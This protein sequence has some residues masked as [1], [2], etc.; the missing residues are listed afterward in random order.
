MSLAAALLLGLAAP[1]AASA[2]R[3]LDDFRAPRAWRQT[4]SDGVTAAAARFDGGLRLDYDFSR[5]AGYAVLHRDLALDLPENFELRFRLRGGG[6]A[7]TLELKLIDASGENVWWHRVPDLAA[8]AGWTRMRVRRRQIDFAWGPARDHALGQIAAI[9]F[10]V[11]AGRGGGRGWIAIDDLEIVPLPVPPAVPPPVTAN[12]NGRLA[13]DG[14]QATAWRGG[15]DAMLDLDLGYAREFGGLRLDW[16]PNAAPADY[17]ISLSSDGLHWTLA[18]AMR[19]SDGGTDWIRLPEAEARFVRIAPVR[20][21]VRRVALAEA[22]IE[23]LAFGASDNDFVAVVAAAAPRGAYPRG[24]MASQNYWTLVAPPM[25]GRN[26]LIDEA[27]AIEFGRGGVSVEPF[28]LDGGRAIGW[29]DGATAQSLARGDLPIPSVERTG[30][31]WRLRITALAAPGRLIGRYTLTNVGG[32]QRR[33]VLLLAV[34]PFQV[35]PPQQF[36]GG[37]GGVSPI[38]SLAWDGRALIVNAAA[39]FVPGS[40]PTGVDLASFDAGAEP[41]MLA[42]APARPVTDPTGLAAGA[43]RYDLAL[44]AG[45]SRTIFIV[46][47]ADGADGADGAGDAGAVEAQSQAAWAQALDRVG[48]SGPPAAAPAFATLRLALAQI[49]MSRDGPALRPGT[50]SYARSWIRDG[51]MMASALLRLGQGDAARAFLDWYAPHQYPDGKVP[52]CVDTRG[53]DPVAENDSDGELI[54]LAAEIQRYAPDEAR[55]RR[56]WPHIRAAAD[57]I[58]RLVRQTRIPANLETSRRPLYGLLPPSISHEGYSA[59]PAYSYWDDFWALAGLEDAAWLA[60]ELRREAEARLLR[61]EADRFRADLLASLAAAR[62]RHRIDFI[63]GAADLG[64]F[65]PTS[66]T[67]ALSVAGLQADLDARQLA[68]TFERY[69]AEASARAAGRAAWQAYTPYE[70]RNVG[71]FVRLGWRDRIP[72]LFAFLME[73]R[74][75]AAWNQWA[76]VVGRDVRLPRFI[77]D[78]PHGWVASDYINALLDMLAYARAGD[79]ALVIGAGVP[80]AWLADGGIR[81]E[82]LRTQWGLLS[83]SLRAE[84]GRIRIAYRL[85]GRAPPGGLVLGLGGGHRLTGLGGEAEWPQ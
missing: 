21:A 23:P 63:P 36:L 50:R 35:N 39:R 11:S 57:H 17:D 51:A 3:L 54:H 76:E 38:R 19:G 79:Q 62:D 40:V 46:S 43:L 84:A 70:W 33:L 31:G 60:G 16:L 55:L 20:G 77:G 12:G 32:A 26:A 47:P 58:D 69:W 72:T 27:G 52:C 64:D 68:A 9:E 42:L 85:D 34:R 18:R 10:V 53:A 30:D 22:A 45:E 7:N 74:R 61:A 41:A 15:P 73:G 5:G 25:G 49:L 14:D 82:R 1:A 37:A 6:P 65:D 78:M 8:P 83:F 59:R 81:V 13:V 56:L 2:P 44:A 80:D 75:P 28:I 48:L 4:A 66:T 71:A 67:I 29:A 24:F